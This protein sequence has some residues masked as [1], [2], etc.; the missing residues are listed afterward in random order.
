MIRS[1]VAGSVMSPATVSR[2]GSSDGLMV[3]E[4]ATT[5][6]PWRGTGDEA[7]ADALRAAG[8]DGDLL[9]CSV[10]VARSAVGECRVAWVRVER[11]GLYGHP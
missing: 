8:D 9:S 3:R 2:S 1:A 7:G 6:Q 11:R 5:A 10:K 4:L